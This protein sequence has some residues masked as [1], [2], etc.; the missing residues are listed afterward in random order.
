MEHKV[1][2]QYFTD[3]PSPGAILKGNMRR[4]QTVADISPSCMKTTHN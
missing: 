2:R 1:V 3:V 4:K